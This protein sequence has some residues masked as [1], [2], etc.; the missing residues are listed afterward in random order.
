MSHIESVKKFGIGAVVKGT[1][2]TRIGRIY[3][4]FRY[5]WVSVSSVQSVFYLGSLLL[6]LPENKTPKDFTQSAY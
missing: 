2:M 6:K 3:T 5:P 4:D 1:R